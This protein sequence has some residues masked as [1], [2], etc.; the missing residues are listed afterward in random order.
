MAL[1]QIV[2]PTTAGTGGRHVFVSYSHLDGVTRETAGEMTQSG[3]RHRPGGVRVRLG[4][5]PYAR[6]LASMGLPKR[7]MISSSADNVE[8]TFSDAKEMA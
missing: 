8:M 6:E 4:T 7:A 5:H 2:P 3:V 1:P